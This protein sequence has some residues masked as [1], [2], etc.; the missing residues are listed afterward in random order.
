MLSNFELIDYAEKEDYNLIGVFSKDRLPNEKRV[1]SYIINMQDHHDGNGTHW[2]A[3]IIFENAKCLYFD[4]YG[5]QA[6][7][8]ILE[9]LKIFKPI[10]TN[11]RQ[12]QYIDSDMCGYFCLAFIKWFN[13]VDPKK[14]DVFELYDDFINAFSNNLKL[15]DK[16]VMEILNKD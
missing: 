15:N 2:I 10:A 6:P 9:Y 1:G 8:N 12:I 5:V 13:S 11:K 14:H 7:K 4:S 16:I 3:F